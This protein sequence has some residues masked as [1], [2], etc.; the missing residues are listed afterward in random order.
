MR[1]CCAVATWGSRVIVA[2]LALSLTSLSAAPR[3]GASDG[4]PA[5]RDDKKTAAKALPGPRPEYTAEQVVQIVMDAL[6]NN[7]EADSGIAV[8]FNFASPENKKA[9]GPLERFT[10][11]VKTEAYRPMLRFRSADHGPVRT[12]DGAAEQVVTLVAADGE[13]ASYVFRLSKQTEG[14]FKGCWMTDGVYRVEPKGKPA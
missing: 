3:E 9:T 12:A 2:V 11:M 7:D 13:I 6:Q 5:P 1:T 4:Q 10:P 8:T 14:E